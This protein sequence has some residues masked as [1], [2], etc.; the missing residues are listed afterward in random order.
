MTRCKLR[1]ESILYNVNEITAKRSKVGFNS[2]P[3]ETLSGG[4]PPP[5]DW[6]D[7]GL[8]SGWSSY[9]EG[10]NPSPPLHSLASNLLRGFD[11]RTMEW[12]HSIQTLRDNIYLI[13]GVIALLCVVMF[14]SFF[15]K[16]YENV[17]S[18]TMRLILSID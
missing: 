14:K 10:R 18:S 5:I 13:N 8:G 17:L 1:W 4:K 7:P 15:R 9:G 11:C 2:L 3:G 12:L 6:Y 16:V